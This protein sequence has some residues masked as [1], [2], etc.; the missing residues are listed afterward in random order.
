M[1]EFCLVSMKIY[2]L[3]SFE[4]PEQTKY[5]TRFKNQGKTLINLHF[6]SFFFAWKQI[7]GHYVWIIL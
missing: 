4:T 3:Q 6:L 2:A 1:S 5:T 7:L